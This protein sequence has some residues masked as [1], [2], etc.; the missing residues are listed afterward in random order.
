MDTLTAEYRFAPYTPTAAPL[1]DAFVD[2]GRN[3]TFLHR[4]AYMDYHADRFRDCS[5]LAYRRD[6][7]CAL[8]PATLLANGV[9]SSHAGL[10]YGGWLLPPAHFDGAMLL[11]MMTAWVQWCRRAGI[12]SIDYKPIPDI[13]ARVPS[14]E[15]RYALWRL[16]FTQSSVNLSSAIDLRGEWKFDM[17]KR[18]QLRRAL[19]SAPQI[20][21]TE[22]FAP[23][24]A[25]LCTCLEQ[26]HQA[27]PVHSLAE[28]SRLHAA[29]PR[30]IRLFTLSLDDEIQAGVCIYD[31]GL[32]AHSQYAATTLR[33]RRDGFLTLLYH[34][35]LTEVFPSRRYFDF[36]TSNEEGGRVL[37]DGLLSQ[38]YALGGTGVIYPRYT[39]TL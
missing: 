24:W 2:A 27:A 31:T 28:I 35:L 4:R 18:Q 9:F 33:A 26:R 15:D 21:E 14:Q 13:Y 20:Q 38:K 10:T 12:T 37:N 11:E 39:L 30:N 22:D 3:A 5:L 17:S 8:L 23:F 29:F 25:L 36:G 6:R 16:G 32:V 7:L 1:W 34:H 19:R